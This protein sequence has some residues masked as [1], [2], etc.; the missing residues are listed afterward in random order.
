[1]SPAT[2]GLAL[3][4]HTRLIAHARKL[5]VD[6][7]LVLVR[8]AAERFLF[9]LSRSRQGDRF[10]LKG[11]M[12]MLAWF[13]ETI[14][15]T[16]DADLLGLEPQSDEALL[17]LFKE[18]CAVAVEADGMH[19]DP[20]TVRVSAI[21][22]GDAGGGRRVTL[23]G[24][25]GNAKLGVQVDVGWGDAI[26]PAARWLQYPTMLD[27][28]QP[29][30]R[31]YPPETVIAEKFHA[32][33]KLGRLNSRMRD[34]HDVLVLQAERDF[35]GSTLVRAV[36]ATFRRRETALPAGRPV[37]LTEEFAQEAAQRWR[38]FVL[39]NGLRFAPQ[40]FEP[41]VAALDHFL[42]PVIEALPGAGTFTARWQRGGPWTGVKR[43]RRSFARR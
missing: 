23:Q 21:R 14:R 6:P 8:Y 7:N 30:L 29:R 36:R 2:T 33:V 10:V 35:R 43:G 3:S 24:R 20:G 39:K 18:V 12:L 13:G 22:E 37:A 41:V 26:T 16:R 4:V 31:A 19:F 5:D 1:M 38:A 25:L 42:S 32:M 34:F 40:E 9:R 11:A 17:A 28:P 27:L 15:P